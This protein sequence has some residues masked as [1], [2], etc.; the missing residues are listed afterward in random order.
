[1]R[2]HGIEREPHERRV[3]VAKA[4]NGNKWQHTEFFSEI[5]RFVLKSL[6]FTR[7]KLA[8]KQKDTAILNDGVFFALFFDYLFNHQSLAFVDGV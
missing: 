6:D 5:K 8:V 3:F 2:Q 7:Q 1:L 4:N